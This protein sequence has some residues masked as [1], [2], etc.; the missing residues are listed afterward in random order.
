MGQCQGQ[1][2]NLGVAEPATWHRS[3]QLGVGWGNL[4][5][6]GGVGE[7]PTTHSRTDPQYPTP[8]AAISLCPIVKLAPIRMKFPV[9]CCFGIQAMTFSRDASCVLIILRYAFVSVFDFFLSLFTPM[10]CDGQW[11][12]LRCDPKREEGWVTYGVASCCC[13]V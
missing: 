13:S 7:A 6:N 8:E 5:R 2:T 3:A 12:Q 1:Q 9:M 11:Q 4:R 10:L